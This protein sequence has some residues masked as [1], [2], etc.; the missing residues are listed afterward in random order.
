M[1][2]EHNFY[3]GFTG[4]ISEGGLFIAT[5]APLE[6]GSIV[7]IQFK[8]PNSQSEISV[9]GEVRWVRDQ[10]AAGPGAP[11]GMGVQF[12]NLSPEAQREIAAFVN[13]REPEFYPEDD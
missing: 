10:S 5:E 3:V 11:A 9:K 8:L 2:T 12:S 13:K 7:L 4:N 6:I 1:N